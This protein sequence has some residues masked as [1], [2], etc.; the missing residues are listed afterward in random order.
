MKQTLGWFAE[1]FVAV[2]WLLTSLAAAALGVVILMVLY[3][4][5][6]E[7]DRLDGPGA[8]IGLGLLVLAL[9]ANGLV[10]LLWLLPPWPR[11]VVGRINRAD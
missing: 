1:L 4:M 5:V 7:G 2:R 11:W 9:G 10:G 8:N 6:V 3:A